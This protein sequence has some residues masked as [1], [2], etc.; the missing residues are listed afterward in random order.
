MT[1]IKIFKIYNGLILGFDIE[2]QKLTDVPINRNIYKGMLAEMKKAK[3]DV[4]DKLECF[5][6][7]I[8]TIYE[9]EWKN[10]PKE[11]W[12]GSNPPKTW[13]VSLR[14][15]IETQNYA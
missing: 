13:A 2:N 11:Y 15:D 1:T 6:K 12:N 8:F 4:D 7:R 14:K 9:R 3:I 5:N 10:A